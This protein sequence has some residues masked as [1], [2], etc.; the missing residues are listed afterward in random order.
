MGLLLCT[1]VSLVLFAAAASTASAAPVDAQPLRPTATR[2]WTAQVIV[3]TVIRAAPGGRRVGLLSTS[4]RWGGGPVRLLVLGSRRS[5][6]RWLRVRLHT[7]PNTAAAWL[8][9]DRVRLRPTPWRVRISTS[10]R[11]LTVF[12]AGRPVRR[13]AAVVGASGTPTPHGLFAIGERIRQ[14]GGVLGPWALHLT[15]HSSVLFDFGGGAG[16]VA[17]HG[18]AGS[19]LADPLGS[20]RSHGCVRLDNGAVSWLAART[21]EGT[22][23]S[24]SR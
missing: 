5:G 14:S 7:R 19:L 3:P 11:T 22:P 20:A 13:F 16:R 12:R 1:I 10:R 15:A 2:A 24:I 18:R 9:A 21:R 17:I 4:A 23:V 8:P 6:R